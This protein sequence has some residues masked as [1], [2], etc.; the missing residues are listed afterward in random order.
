[1][2]HLQFCLLFPGTEGGEVDRRIAAELPQPMSGCSPCLQEVFQLE[3][4][5]L[6]DLKCPGGCERRRGVWGGRCGKVA[7]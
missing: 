4:V 5:V 3:A 1:M 7:A 2:Q 6:L